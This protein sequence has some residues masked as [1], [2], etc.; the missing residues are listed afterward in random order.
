M[1]VVNLAMLD[2][3]LPDIQ[4]L[5]LSH[6]PTSEDKNGQD[7][8][9]LRSFYLKKNHTQHLKDRASV[10]Q[11]HL[12]T[13]GI[14]LPRA[15]A[16]NV[17]AKVDGYRSFTAVHH[18]RQHAPGV[19]ATARNRFRTLLEG[20]D[21]EEVVP[22]YVRAGGQCCPACGGN[23]I[24]EEGESNADAAHWE[25]LMGCD[26]PECGYQW[27]AVYQLTRRDGFNLDT[28]K[29]QKALKDERC[30]YC[31]EDDFGLTYGNFWGGSS[32]Y[33]PVKCEDCGGNW[34]DIYNLVEF[35]EPET[36]A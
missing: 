21:R 18:G 16:L 29:A 2:R 36:R 25:I 22:D 1:V 3:K 31:E 24:A 8:K 34:M 5:A 32:G 7:P 9:N 10:L 19:L 6:K 11:A 12:K 20:Y 17:M 23:R 33:Q 14:T 27:W 15:E 30:P 35:A 28:V 4:G 26:N 13:S